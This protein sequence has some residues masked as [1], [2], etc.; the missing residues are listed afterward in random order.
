MSPPMLSVRSLTLRFGAVTAFDEVSFDVAAG[1][2][3]AVIGP[4]GAGKTSLFN[5]VSRV[6]APTAGDVRLAGRDMRALRPSDLAGAGVARTF[7]N[8]GLFGRLSVE[9]NVLIG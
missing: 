3:F 9:E 7:Q 1:E 6:F 8:L 4:N 2:L 5:V